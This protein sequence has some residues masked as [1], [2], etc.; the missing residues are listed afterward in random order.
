MATMN[1]TGLSELER[2]RIRMIGEE[3]NRRRRGNRFRGQ[4][5]VTGYWRKKTPS[6]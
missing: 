3:H 5:W 6:R 4:V 1:N 2:F